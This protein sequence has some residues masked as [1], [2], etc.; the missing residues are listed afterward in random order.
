MSNISR[1]TEQIRDQFAQ[2]Q[3]EVRELR[4]LCKDLKSRGGRSSASSLHTLS[5]LGGS[6]TSIHRVTTTTSTASIDSVAS[7]YR[8]AS[9]IE[10]YC[11]GLESAYSL[12][13][14]APTPPPEEVSAEPISDV[15][16]SVFAH[17]P[18]QPLEDLFPESMS[19][20]D[21]VDPRI[22]FH[23]LE[24]DARDNRRQPFYIHTVV[25][26]GKATRYF[27]IGQAPAET[28]TRIGIDGIP[29]WYSELVDDDLSLPDVRE[30]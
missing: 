5:A 20:M 8:A 26:G 19:G 9:F 13:I 29:K 21:V 14:N 30:Y 10:Y 18:T 16:V 11:N 28:T 7:T 24:P 15:D 25:R 2:L 12:P 27:R 17:P 23:T 22:M 3:M 6:S 1:T 4:A